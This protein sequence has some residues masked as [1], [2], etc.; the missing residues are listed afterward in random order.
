[1]KLENQIW[2]T[3]A[4]PARRLKIGKKIIFGENLSAEVLEKSEEGRVFVKFE[5]DGD[6]DEILDEIGKTPLPPYIKRA[7][8]SWM[9][10][11][12]RYQTVF[13]KEKGAIAAP[14]A[15]LH[16]TPQI[17]EEIK[18][19]GVQLPKS[20]FTSVTELLSRCASL[21]CRNIKLCPKN[22]KFPK[23]PPKF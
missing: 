14:T 17:L 9:T 20:L 1:M 18:N 15:G 19:L 22:A 23:K 3:L 7:K 8:G 13:A 6:F 5:A 12:E 10:D 16:F 11:R 2:E 21:I 4:R